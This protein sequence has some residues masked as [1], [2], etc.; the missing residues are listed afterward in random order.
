MSKTSYESILEKHVEELQSLFTRLASR[1]RKLVYFIVPKENVRIQIQQYFYEDISSIL[2][3]FVPGHSMI[4][5]KIDTY[6]NVI[7]EIT[8]KIEIWAI[9]LYSGERNKII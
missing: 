8:E 5:C 2:N 9:D 6:D 1:D 4:T 3:I 7:K